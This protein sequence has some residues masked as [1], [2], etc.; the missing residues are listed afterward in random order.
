MNVIY[1]WLRYDMLNSS[2]RRVHC[3][4]NYEM[5]NG[6]HEERDGLCYISKKEILDDRNLCP[7]Q[8]YFQNTSYLST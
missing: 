7:I 1:Q 2:A 8:H 3:L 5:E 6:R 4:W